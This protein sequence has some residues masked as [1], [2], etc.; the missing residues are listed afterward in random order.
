MRPIRRE[1]H[2]RVPRPLDEV[3]DFFSRPQNLGKMTPENVSFT[4]T[5]PDAD[6]L[7]YEG[8]VIQYRISPFLGINLDWMTE[9]THIESKRYFVDDQRAGPYALWHHQHHFAA[10]PDGSTLMRDVLHYQV[11]FGPI[12]S[13]ANALFVGSQI[14]QIFAYREE[15]AQRMFG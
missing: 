13:L 5:S 10:Q 12:G 2:L 4:I 11:P 15:A 14:D 8:M 7:M 9:I 1:W 6:Q 3:W